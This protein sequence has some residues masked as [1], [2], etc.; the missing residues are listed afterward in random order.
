MEGINN[1]KVDIREVCLFASV[2]LCDDV[3]NMVYAYEQLTEKENHILSLN[4]IY[5]ILLLM[6][7]STVYIE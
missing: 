1:R 7:Q 2:L 5:H 6:L 4:E 3:R